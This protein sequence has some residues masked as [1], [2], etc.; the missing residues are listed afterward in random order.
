MSDIIN[1]PNDIMVNSILCKFFRK[2]W[3]VGMLIGM[4]TPVLAQ[5]VSVVPRPLKVEQRAGYYV[6]TPKTIISFN[7]LLVEQAAYLSDVLARSTGYQLAVKSDVQKRG[8]RL[9]VDER[10]VA[11]DEGYQ[12][13]VDNSGV[14]IV[15]HDVG[16]VFYGIQT[17]L[18]LLPAAVYSHEVQFGMSWKVPFVSISDAPN[19]PWRGMMLDVARYYYPVAFV[20]KF[21]DM[22]AVYKM[23]ML[24]LH[25]VDDSGW[26][27]EIK[28]YPRLTEVGA[29]GGKEPHRL[30]GYYTQDEMRELISYAAV[31]NVQIVPEIEFPAHLLSAIVAYPWLSCTGEQHE[32]QTQHFISQDL[33]CVGKET[34]IQFLNDVLDETA[35]LFP[36]L[37]INIGGDEAVYKRWEE[38][39]RCQEVMRREHLSKASEL[40]GYLTNVVSDMMKDQGRTIVGWEEIVD[41]GQLNN[42]VVAVMWHHVEDTLKATSKGHQAI[43]APASHFYLDFPES[44]TPGEIKAATWMPPISLEKCYSISVNDHSPSSRVLGVQGCLWSDQF[45]VGTQLQELPQLNENRSEQYVEYLAFPRMMAVAEVGWTKSALRN[46]T[47]FSRRSASHYARLDAM[48]GNYRV[49]EP[50]LVNATELGNGRYSISVTPS[51]D[52]AEVRYTTDGTYPNAHSPLYTE[53]VVVDSLSAFRAITVVEPTHFSLPLCPERQ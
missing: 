46:Y 20:K 45:I 10:R 33:L 12:L 31:R 34:S 36:S 28:K 51:V 21:I 47:D 16:G 38:C 7:G 1:Q 48:G 9:I 19:H 5:D 26:R 49:P 39:P 52:G 37:Y 15:G 25:L 2:A 22:M 53:P 14:E 27:L 23:N 17:L 4:T 18:Q 6:I 13:T 40:Q 50:R 32:V 35:G 8:I 29:W 43:V 41:R 3:L 11:Q 44:S 42:P 30:G 24:Q